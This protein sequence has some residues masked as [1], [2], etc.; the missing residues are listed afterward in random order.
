[1]IGRAAPAAIDQGALLNG[2]LR[3][4]ELIATG[5]PLTETLEELCRIIDALCGRI[6]CVYLFNPDDGRLRFAAGPMLPALFRE[7]TRSFIATPTTTGAC[8][9]AV[10]RREAVIV[11]DALVS[12]LYE[13]WR[14]EIRDSG[15]RSVWSTPFL[16]Q[17]GRVLGTFA[18]VSTEPRVPSEL[19]RA[20]V[21]RATRLASIAVERHQ[22]D[23][24]LRESEI[25]F[26]RAFYANPGCMTITSFAEERFLYVNDAFV[27]MFGYSRVEAV[28]QTALALGLYADPRERTP[29]TE[30]LARGEVRNVEVKGRNKAG[31]TLDITLS[32]E[33]I[34]ILGEECVLAIAADMTDRNRAQES[35]RRSER[36]LRLVLDAA[37]VGIAVV[38]PAGNSI[39][40]NPASA[41]VW[42]G[43]IIQS[44]RERYLQSKGWWHDTGR[45]IAPDEWASVR[46]RVKGE[47]SVNEVIDI[48]AYDG[49]RK[50]IHNS[51]VPI[52][53]E[54]QAIVGAVVVNEDITERTATER[55]LEAS[56]REMHLLATRLMHAQDD[57]R[58]RIAQMLH[59][60]T[61]QDLAALKMMLARVS[62]TSKALSEGDRH[63]LAEAVDLAEQS[64]AGVRTLSYLL[65][66]PFLDEQGLLSALRWYVEGFSRRSGIAVDLD[67]P[68]ALER[69]PQ[70]V[71]TTL[72]RIV[73]EAL[74]NIH[75]HADS[76]TARIRL[77]T[78]GD[79]LTLEIEDRG[80]GM[81]PD[82]VARLV[83]GDSAF[84]IGVAGMRERL[85][86]LGG[87]FDI[88]SSPAGTTVRVSVP[89]PAKTA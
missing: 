12:P 48:E 64:M 43:P 20:L 27:R 78:A 88:E 26:S 53:D 32:M 38:D 86:R 36:L 1:M 10:Y 85:K 83:D 25:R 2:A 81:S 30:R 18:V 54:H 89:V 49:V 21:T 82:F 40:A 17:E 46:A 15:I 28:G 74:I 77:R 11:P 60:T 55:A 24:R 7:A 45:R 61:A 41:R 5:A 19:F 58:R 35:L 79:G 42:D 71:E 6:S 34:E 56:V 4:L 47:T 33:R 51:A 37:P 3:V 39:L 63:V 23:E 80:R 76:P 16:G 69:F 52:R 50:V 72:F 75:R 44:G 29:V 62:R 87:S 67:L 31:Q 68:K 73:Q 70:A 59:E 57:E 22:A 84:G 66:P 8:G 9:A 13:L 14:A 65:H